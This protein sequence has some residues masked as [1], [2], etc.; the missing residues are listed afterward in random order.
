MIVALPTAPLTK[1]FL[2]SYFYL[3]ISPLNTIA[4][5]AID[6]PYGI[7]IPGGVS[8]GVY[9]AG[10]NWTLIELIRYE[11]KQNNDVRLST[12]TGASAGSINTILSAMRYC[13]D[14]DLL[15][16]AT[17]N[18]F[19]DTWDIDITKLAPPDHSSYDSFEIEG[20]TIPD[21]LLSRAAFA[22]VVDKIRNRL[23]MPVYRAGCSLN[24][25]IVS[26]RR[27]P[28][29][30]I[31]ED[32]RN[33][34]VN[35]KSQRFLIPIRI[36]T[37]PNTRTL[38]FE[39]LYELTTATDSTD[40]LLF[41]PE[42]EDPITE[43][44]GTIAI[45]HIIRAAFASSAFPLAFSPIELKYCGKNVTR[46][47]EKNASKSYFIDGG[48]HDNIPLRAA[49]NL[50]DLNTAVAKK[51]N[52]IFIHL[53]NTTF[54]DVPNQDTSDN[55]PL[56]LREQFAPFAPAIDIFRKQDIYRAYTE[57]FSTK[58]KERTLVVTKRSR[59]V[60]GHFLGAFGAFFDP[61]FRRHD[62]A[63]GIIDGI[64][65]FVDHRCRTE[66]AGK[67]DQD[68]CRSDKRE[69]YMSF[70][71]PDRRDVCSA[72]PSVCAVIEFYLEDAHIDNDPSI[73]IHEPSVAIAEVFSNALA[74][75][76]LDV[77]LE[78]DTFIESLSE[79]LE[80]DNQTKSRFDRFLRY[81]LDA[82]AEAGLNDL[83]HFFVGR[84]TDIEAEQAELRKDDNGNSLE[85]L[86]TLPVLLPA[87]TL[88]IFD[89]IRFNNASPYP[90][91]SGFWQR[92][93]PDYIGIEGAQTGATFRWDFINIPIGDS[94]IARP[95][96]EYSFGFTPP[97]DSSLDRFNRVGVG[98]QLGYDLDQYGISELGISLSAGTNNESEQTPAVTAYARF[99]GG[100]VEAAVGL[101]DVEESLQG[102]WLLR[103]GWS[104]I[105]SV[106][107]T[108][109]KSK[110]IRRIKQSAPTTTED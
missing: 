18:L 7:T 1:L 80:K 32:N 31:P 43:E 107:R 29:V 41:L 74:T 53:S 94:L 100:K 4:N 93:P 24:T 59:P 75:K 82:S 47:T 66:I 89:R 39:N 49:T 106:A 35:I 36:Y 25:G 23:G 79:H 33:G 45:D 14:D 81:S 10:I 63:V 57:E 67:R 26:T 69:E 91:A 61:A 109:A 9:E 102:R 90:Y 56:M 15:P 20:N 96:L 54:D 55:A 46:C 44:K 95:Q 104:D 71:F 8:L 2:L 83:L 64:S 42:E 5:P 48:L 30:I 70:L 19:F 85:L 50:Y 51:G 101:I 28:E 52:F 21:L 92:M 65:S 76:K 6:Q 84:Q 72:N 105:D 37:D 88:G 77:Y 11:Q 58:E 98:L 86:R 99:F 16:Q 78:Y 13:E 97:E 110:F 103:I 62:Y 22:D 34:S 17:D 60:T 87:E 68:K 40:L 27:E 108:I 3:L 12:L 38:K 73:A